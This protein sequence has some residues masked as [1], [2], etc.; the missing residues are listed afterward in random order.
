[1]SRTVQEPEFADAL[2]ARLALELVPARSVTGPGRSGAIASVY[3]S[4][5]LGVPFIPFG[6]PCPPQ[7]R[8]LLVVDT[9]EQSGRTL[10]KAVRRYETDGDVRGIAIY[11]EPP[12]VRFW[13][14][15][16]C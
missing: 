14:E 15:T 6:A 13:Y 3:A 8:P 16:L 4:H 10:R 5:L 1:M 2:R 12:R 11:S 9:A 7:L